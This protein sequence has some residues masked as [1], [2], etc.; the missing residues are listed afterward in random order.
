MLSVR[1]GTKKKKEK[2]DDG[3]RENSD[4]MRNPHKNKDLLHIFDIN[5][6]TMTGDG[7][8]FLGRR[9]LDRIAS[10]EN[11]VK[12]LQGAALG[13][14]NEDPDNKHLDGVPDGEYNICLPTNPAHGD[15]PGELVEKTGGIDGE[16]RER[17]TLGTHFKGQNFNRIQGLERGD[18]DRVAGTEY[19]DECE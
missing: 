12:L 6:I 13:L 2:P 8:S 14:R 10:C 17:H 19:E 4:E 16:G 7:E 5:D 3:M 18:T 9:C 1:H 11:L 15:G